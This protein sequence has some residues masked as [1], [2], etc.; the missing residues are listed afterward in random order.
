MSDA[1]DERIFVTEFL[2]LNGALVGLLAIEMTSPIEAPEDRA[3]VASCLLNL[4]TIDVRLD[5]FQE[6]ISNHL[7]HLSQRQCWKNLQLGS[8]SSFSSLQE[9]QQL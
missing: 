5:I 4:E 1:D 3:A 2:R 7:S 9:F 8:I 6:F